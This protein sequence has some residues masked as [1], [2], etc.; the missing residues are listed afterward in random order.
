[1][2]NWRNHYGVG[3]Q[4]TSS[5]K[6]HPRIPVDGTWS[7]QTPQ[8]WRCR[9]NLSIM[10]TIRQK[11]PREWK[12]CSHNGT[13]KTTCIAHVLGQ[14]P[15]P[16]RRNDQDM[17]QRWW[18]QTTYD[19]WG[20]QR[21]RIMQKRTKKKRRSCDHRWLS[22]QIGV[23]NPMVKMG[24]WSPQPFG[25]YCWIQW[26]CTVV[27]DPPEIRTRPLR[28]INVGWEKILAVP[29]TGNKYKLEALAVHNIIRRRIS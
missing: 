13:T 21:T 15:A 28:S 11:K 27:C 7:K 12:I 2:D 14:R 1:M 25:N 23:S 19:D 18:T 29:H 4:L 6:Q 5:K 26:R 8:W 3:H 17:Q 22:S 9:S 20:S 10:R 16:T 24:N